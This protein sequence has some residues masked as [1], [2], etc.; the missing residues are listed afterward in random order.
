MPSRA[1]AVGPQDSRQVTEIIIA[2]R[3]AAGLDVAGLSALLY[4]HR[5][6]THPQGVQLSASVLYH[7]ERK[8][9][10]MRLITVD[11][12]KGF[13][14]VLPIPPEVILS[15]LYGESS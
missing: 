4:A 6:P 3:E 15:W 1:R 8:G 2:A 9:G 14:E 13:A 5:C 7:I 12:L 10:R 11:E